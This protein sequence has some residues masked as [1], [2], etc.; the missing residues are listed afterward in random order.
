MSKH[1]DKHLDPPGDT[2][3]PAWGCIL[4]EVRYMKD[5]QTFVLLKLKKKYMYAWL[6]SFHNIYKIWTWSF[7]NKHM[8]IFKQCAIHCLNALQ[9]LNH[10]IVTTI[11]LLF[12][13]CRWVIR[14]TE[15][16]NDL[17]KVTRLVMIINPGSLATE[18]VLFITQPCC[19][20]IYLLSTFQVLGIRLVFYTFYRKGHWSLERVK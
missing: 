4:P 2:R 16:L 1:E 14:D 9:V 20:N 10:E 6:S 3:K 19:A 8:N 11:L 5:R 13:F 15:R 18:S 7:F 17:L 12:P